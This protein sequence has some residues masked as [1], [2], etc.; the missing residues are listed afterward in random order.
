MYAPAS[1]IKPTYTWEPKFNLFDFKTPTSN[2]PVTPQKQV[3]FWTQNQSYLKPTINITAPTTVKP[4]TKFQPNTIQWFLDFSKNNPNLETRRNAVI[5]MLQNGEDESFVEDTILNKMQLNDFAKIMAQNKTIWGRLEQVAQST[6][7][8]MQSNLQSDRGILGKELGKAG[9][10]ASG[11]SGIIG[12]WVWEFFETA[13]QW[14]YSGWPTGKIL[15]WVK[16][17]WKDIAK[18]GL[19]TTAWTIWKGLWMAWSDIYSRIPENT[20]QTIQDVGSIGMWALDVAW[21]WATGKQVLKSGKLL[22]KNV[23]SGVQKTKVIPQKIQNVIDKSKDAKLEKGVEE[24]YE[25]VNPTTKENKAQLRKRV[26]DLLPYIDEKNPLNNEL[27]QVKTRV[28]IDK[29]KAFDSMAEYEKNVW[30]RWSVETSPIIKKIQDKFIEKTS[31]WIIINEEQARIANEMIKK[32]EE[33]WPII[34]DSDIIKVRRSWDKIIE[35]NKWFMQSAD[36]NMKWDIFNEANKFFREEIKKSNPVYASYLEKASKTINL[37]DILD[38]T[39][40]R[41][42]G[43]SQWGYLRR[44]GENIARVTWVWMW[45]MI[46]W[47]PWAIVWDLATEALIKWT[48]KLTGSSVKLTRWKKLILKNKKNGI[49]NND[50]S[51]RSNTSVSWNKKQMTSWPRLN[52]KA[53]LSKAKIVNPQKALERK[54]TPTQVQEVKAKVEANKPKIVNNKL[55]PKSEVNKP[56]VKKSLDNKW[57]Y[58]N[59]SAIVDDIT[60]AIKTLT[61]KNITQLSVQIASRLKVSVSKVQAILKEYVQKYGTELKNKAWDLFDD[62]ADRLGVRSKLVDGKGTGISGKIDT[63]KKYNKTFNIQDRNDLEYLKRIL[64]EEKLEDL[65]NGN[66]FY[67]TWRWTTY[68]E[69]VKW[70]II[71]KKPQSIQ[72]EL[73][74]KVKDYIPKS[75]TF[76]HWTSLENSNNILKT[77]YKAWS[78]LPSETFRGGWYGKMQSSISFAETPKEA[79][80]FASLTKNGKIIESKLKD[81]AKVVTID[82]IEDAI[83]LEDYIPYLKKN[84]IDA[85]Y[86]WGWEKELVVINPKSITPVRIAKNPLPKIDAPKE[87]IEEAKKYKSAE[88]FIKNTKELPVSLLRNKANITEEFWIWIRNRDNLTWYWKWTSKWEFNDFVKDIKNNWIKNQIWIYIESDWKITISDWTHRLLAAEELWFKNVPVSI[89]WNINKFDFL[90]QIWQQANK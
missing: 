83:D 69:I 2:I 37:S 45:A 15:Q 59:P 80:I 63:P 74:W 5:Q 26:E 57:G 42:T 4:S 71:S 40:Q 68:E 17:V 81:N 22:G 50:I 47:V 28:D 49:N 18:S 35:R 6:N 60:K 27:V 88:E 70:N 24:I 84:S 31:D 51:P 90:K 38:A 20:R 19:W 77:W 61:H 44:S 29:Q 72:Q 65:K 7:E 48:R 12:A 3:S 76:Y 86:I 13:N 34:K 66:K 21:V 85:V 41:R 33:F 46:W 11:I 32:L 54:L 78:E 39:I 14:A 62:L 36:A 64:W 87:L 23:V 10:V 25:A 58:I 79:N 53:E 8:R 43:Q 55:V 56:V 82:W 67:N 9:A 89:L 52:S 16:A 1:Y 30:V 75:K 73:A